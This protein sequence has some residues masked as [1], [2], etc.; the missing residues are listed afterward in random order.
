[1]TRDEADVIYEKWHDKTYG[2]EEIC[3]LI[4]LLVDLGVLK[5]DEPDMEA[6]FHERMKQFYG[7]T[8][9]NSILR[10]LDRAGLKVTLK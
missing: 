6:V 9:R 1:M 10:K 8:N 5:L 3:D 4:G 2:G 7:E